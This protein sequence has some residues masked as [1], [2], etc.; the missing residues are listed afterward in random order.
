MS[1][2]VENDSVEW[3]AGPNVYCGAVREVLSEQDRHDYLVQVYDRDAEDFRDVT[4][5]HRAE[6]LYAAGDLRDECECEMGDCT[7]SDGHDTQDTDTGNSGDQDGADADDNAVD[8]SDADAAEK[9]ESETGDKDGT[10]E[11]GDLSEDGDGEADTFTCTGN[12]GECS[13]TV[14]EAGGRCWQ[15]PADDE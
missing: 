3:E 8:D 6:D 14:D 4:L 1:E 2:Y 10:E 15:H 5:R 7:T 12:D 11:Q 9:E 13:R